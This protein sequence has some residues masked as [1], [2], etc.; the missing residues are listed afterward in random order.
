VLER[1]L[2]EDRPEALRQ[3]T[4][5]ICAKFGWV[6]GSGDERQFLEAF[7]AALRARLERDMRFGRRKKDK[8]S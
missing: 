3:V 4:E 5:T 6:P 1:V 7:Y 8:F 2:R